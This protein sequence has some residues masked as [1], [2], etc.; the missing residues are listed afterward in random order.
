[1]KRAF[2]PLLCVFLLACSSCSKQS[3][4]RDIFAMDTIISIDIYGQECEEIADECV[5]EVFRLEKM[6]S[7]TLA[8]SDVSVLNNAGRA[9]VSDETVELINLSLKMRERTSGL[10]DITIAPVMDVWGFISDN[11]AVPE[12]AD[13]E[14][15]M[16]K[17][18]SEI[19]VD[20]N[21]V[22]LENGAAIDLGGIA[23]GYTGDY[24]NQMIKERGIESALISLGGNVVAIGDNG[25]KPWRVAIQNPDDS[26]SYAGILLVEDRHLVTSGGYER[27]FT[28]DGELYHHI[29]DPRTGYPAD[30]GLKSVTIIAESGAV[31]DALS[32]AVYIMGES[33]A[34]EHWRENLDFEM[35]LITQD[36][37]VLVTDGLEFEPVDGGYSYEIIFSEQET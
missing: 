14:R 12:Q 31:A 25:G 17:I 2:I 20:L 28:Q 21:V 11:P 5:A 3:A 29:I 6:F 9:E 22:S 32:T 4:S 30:S 33:E 23:K 27:N 34:I 18:G 35:V 7:R 8:D 24:L 36:N 1:M 15:A 37:R 10:F 16:L 19:N 13:L 26:G